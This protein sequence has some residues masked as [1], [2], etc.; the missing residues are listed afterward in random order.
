MIHDPEIEVTCD[1]TDCNESVFL[2]MC[3]NT[4]GYNRTDESI[5]RLLAMDHDWLVK[6]GS[7]YCE[8]CK[9]DQS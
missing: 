8:N 6:G 5:G 7:H 1:G 4:G 3:W 2:P 9:T